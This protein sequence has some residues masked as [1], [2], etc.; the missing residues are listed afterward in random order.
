VNF[1]VGVAVSIDGTASVY[2]ANRG[3]IVKQNFSQIT[4]ENIM[5]MSYVSGGNYTDADKLVDWAKTNNIAVHG[6][7]LVWHPDYQLPTW[8]KNNQDVKN[9]MKKHCYD[10]ARHF[11]GKVTSWD[12][13]NEALYDP[14]DNAQGQAGIYRNSVFYKAYGSPEY[15]YDCF[16]QARM[17]DGNVEL[18]YNDFNTEENLDKTTALVTLIKNMLNNSVPITG[19]GFQMHVLP[20]WASIDNIKAS[21]KKILDLD[22]NLK[23]KLTELDVRVNNKYANPPKVIQSCNNCPELQQQKQ[24]Y[25]DIVKAYME[26]VPAHR[27]GGITIWGI[28]DGDSWFA[29]DPDW[30][31]LWNDSLQ[32]KP[33]FDGVMEGLKGQ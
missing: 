9:N 23:I 13:V 10:V 20:D 27:R 4:A 7:A 15:I 32:K 12:V 25:K 2:N 1:P 24:R 26:V 6:H 18:Y 30:P 5:K 29:K 17:A 11:A 21:W 14:N 33:A 28:A 31:L 22:P 19:V 16:K 8:A 3:N